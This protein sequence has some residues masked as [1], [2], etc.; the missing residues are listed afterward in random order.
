M[1]PAILSMA[2]LAFGQLAPEPMLTTGSPGVSAPSTKA[3]IDWIGGCADFA[4]QT[5]P[6]KGGAVTVYRPSTE[7]CSC[8]GSSVAVNHLCVS[9]A[10]ARIAASAVV[11]QAI[12]MKAQGWCVSTML[13]LDNWTGGNYLTLQ[14]GDVVA[15]ANSAA[16]TFYSDGL[17]YFDTYD[18]AAT[19]R[20]STYAHG[21]ANAIPHRVMFCDGATGPS[22]WIDNSRVTLSTTGAGTGIATMPAKLYVNPGSTVAMYMSRLA[23]CSRPSGC[24]PNPLAS[25]C[26]ISFS[27]PSSSPYTVPMSSGGSIAIAGSTSPAAQCASQTVSIYSTIGA[28]AESLIGTA[29]TNAS[30][31]FAYTYTIADTTSTVV[32]A[33]MTKAVVSSTSFTAQWRSAVV[34][35]PGAQS[36]PKFG[37]YPPKAADI[38]GDGIPDLVVAAPYAN[39]NNGAIYVFYSSSFPYGAGQTQEIIGPTAGGY[40][41]L[42]FDV[43]DVNG[44]GRADLVTRDTGGKLDVFLAPSNGGH[45]PSSPSFILVASGLSNASVLPDVNGDGFNEIVSADTSGVGKLYVTSGVADWSSRYTPSTNPP[46]V[47]VTTYNFATITGSDAS[48]TLGSKWAMLSAVDWNADGKA[49][50]LIPAIGAKK[51][52][53]FPGATIAGGGALTSSQGT[54]FTITG[55]SASMP[56]AS[57]LADADGDGRLDIFFSDYPNRKIYSFSQ[58]SNHTYTSNA[59]A[60]AWVTGTAT[61]FGYT[62]ATGD[63]NKDSRPD[64]V[65]GDNAAAGGASV[66]IYW[67]SVSGLSTSSFLAIP[68]A[69]ASFGD[70]LLIADLNG[71][72]NPDLVVGDADGNGHVTIY[73]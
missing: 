44:D 19:L 73:Y 26:A 18:A 21:F 55:I 32:R 13:A 23:Q 45:L 28:G 41:G 7:S 43:G 1:I 16:I 64:L 36:T 29:T 70:G 17:I 20:R 58:A 40:F 53:F 48:G 60:S 27:N 30:G 65:V 14:V 69:L 6:A 59:G 56:I 33:Q 57:A 54:G 24:D 52:Y 47:D 61:S 22:L 51:L 68:S 38:D 63:L 49:D 15:A 46:Q 3:L 9:D 67:S 37:Y 5:I 71:D 66:R 31:A 50:M 8:L 39:S 34:A 42:Y 4:D 62:M 35:Y 11:A 25:G 2:A 10:G 12:S 72:G